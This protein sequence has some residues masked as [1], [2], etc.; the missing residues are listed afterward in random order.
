M[1]LSSSGQRP[2]LGCQWPALPRLTRQA[3]WIGAKDDGDE[4]D[5]SERDDCILGLLWAVEPSIRLVRN[6][7]DSHKSKAFQE[8]QP[9]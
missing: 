8:Y 9:V 3:K 6:S 5:K 2:S 4:E 7:E 1:G